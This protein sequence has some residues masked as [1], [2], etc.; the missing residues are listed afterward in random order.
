MTIIAID[1]LSFTTGFGV[2]MVVA[3][4]GVVAGVTSR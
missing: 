2:A 1:W 4:A 3:V